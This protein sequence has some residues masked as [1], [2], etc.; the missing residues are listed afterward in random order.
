VDHERRARVEEQRP[1]QEEHPS[2]HFIDGRFF[3]GAFSTDY[4]EILV[5]LKHDI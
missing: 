3:D 2:V 5:K 4:F 1:K